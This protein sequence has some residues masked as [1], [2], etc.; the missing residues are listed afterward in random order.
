MPAINNANGN[1][2]PGVVGF[3]NLSN[4]MQA[5]MAFLI[6]VSIVYLFLVFTY[7]TKSET[8]AFTGATSNPARSVFGNNN[9][10]LTISGPVPHQDDYER[11]KAEIERERVPQGVTF[12][13]KGWTQGATAG[14]RNFRSGGDNGPQ[15]AL[16]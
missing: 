9:Q 3:T 15:D 7:F 10:N 12:P 4:G 5:L 14:L 16:Y 8:S 1:L 13:S 2:Y 11:H 6:I